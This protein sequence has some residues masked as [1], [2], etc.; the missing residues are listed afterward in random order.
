[1]TASGTKYIKINILVIKF[2]FNRANWIK[3]KGQKY[4]TNC[5]II[6]QVHDENPEFSQID[7]IFIADNKILFAVST[8]NTVTFCRHFHAYEV[9]QTLQHN[10]VCIDELE[11]PYTETLRHCNSKFFV[12]VRDTTLLEL[13]YNYFTCNYIYNEWI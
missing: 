11:F 13:L 8:F 4:K 3:S 12:V 9:K 7:Q 6:I 2:S 5:M 1:M 10:I